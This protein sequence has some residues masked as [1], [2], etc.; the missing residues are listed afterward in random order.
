[1]L[2]IFTILSTDRVALPLSEAQTTDKNG[3]NGEAGKSI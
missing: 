1:M 2:P 3:M